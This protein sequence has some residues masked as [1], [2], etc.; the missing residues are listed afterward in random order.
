MEIRDPSVPCLSTAPGSSG[1]ERGQCHSR[2]G[3][4]GTSARASP[5]SA[6]RARAEGPARP[7]SPL[8]VPAGLRPPEPPLSRTAT[9][10][11]AAT[12]RPGT[13]PAPRKV[14]T[15]PGAP[16]SAS[17]PGAPQRGPAPSARPGPGA[18]RPQAGRAVL[19]GRSA[20]PPKE[21]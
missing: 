4:P 18:A 14:N 15:A 10:G 7:H 13:R 21:R 20:A 5:H 16:R 19:R 12:A 2:P 8:M 11:P 3:P 17:R 1:G 6:R 9:A